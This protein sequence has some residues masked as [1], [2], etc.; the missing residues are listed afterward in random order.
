M[1]PIGKAGPGSKAPPFVARLIW[2]I[3]PTWEREYAEYGQTAYQRLAA[4]SVA[5][6]Y[7]LRSSE[8]YRKRNASYQPTQPTPIPISE[9]CVCAGSRDK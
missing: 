1:Q 9:S 4:I 7:R 2:A 8:G 6:L 3:S 5:H